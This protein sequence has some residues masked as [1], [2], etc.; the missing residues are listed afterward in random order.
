MSRIGNSTAT[1]NKHE[2]T[3][4]TL[5]ASNS[6]NTSV[7]G[8]S[9]AFA[10]ADITVRARIANYC[11]ILRK[12][13]SVSYTQVSTLVAGLSDEFEHQRELKTKEVARDINAALINQVSASG[14]SAVARSLQGVLAAITTNTAD[15]S[16]G[17]LSPA[18][19]NGLAQAIW[20]SSGRPNAVYAHGAP[21][22][23][24]SSWTQPVTRMQDSTGKKITAAVDVY[25]GDFGRVMILL[26]REM[27]LTS[28]GGST[29]TQVALLEEKYWRKAWLRPLFFEEVAKLGGSRRGYVESEVTLEYLAESSS[30]KIVNV[31]AQ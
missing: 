29:V 2:W 5:Q 14:T 30:G 24:I 22:R 28:A 26:E 25:D 20:L 6:A 10:S 4:E 18:I 19:F 9:A 3:T 21:K 31:L 12:T 13:F 7:E 15:A 11:Q 23:Q 1:S 8:V 16:V 17:Q 27:P